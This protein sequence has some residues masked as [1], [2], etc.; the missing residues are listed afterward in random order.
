MRPIDLQRMIQRRAFVFGG[1]QALA[2]TTLLTRLYYLQFVRGEE[3][4][5]E[6]EGNRI[7]V[8]MLVP[9]RGVIADRFGVAMAM[10]HVNYKLMLESQ[11][12]DVA[13]ATLDKIAALLALRPAELDERR[14]DIARA[15]RGFPVLVR[16]YLSW[17]DVATIEFHLP[18]LP[19]A[20]IEEG[21]WRHYPF[22]DHASHLIGYIGKVSPEEATKSTDP[23]LKQPD[24]RLGKNGIEQLYE[25]KLRG[26]AGTRQLEV[27]VV[28]SPVRELAKQEA[29]AGPTL[30]LTID[31]RLQEFVVQR[32]GQ[33]S[34]AVVVMQVHTGEVLALASMPSYDPNEFS[35]GIK[36]GYWTALN[37][38]EKVPLLNK[39]IAGQYPPGS[40]F[41]MMTGLAALKSGKVN[42]ER[43]VYCPGHYYLGSNRWNCWKPEG[44]GAVNFAEALA[45][46]CDTYFY[47]VGREAGIEAIADMCHAFGLGAPS[48]LGLRGE[49]AGIVPSPA[50]KQKARGL[51]WNPGETINTSIG[52]GDVLT[53]PMQ[54]AIMTA[55]MVNGGKKIRP[56]LLLDEP[57]K[58]DGFIDIDPAHLQVALE[59]MNMVTNSPRGTAYGSTIKVEGM[60]FGGKTGTAQVRR[61]TIRGQDQNRI[62]WKFRH[63][64]L[65][66]GFAPAEKPEY[67][68]AV[69]I[70]HGGG[71]A[72]AA[73]PVARDVMQKLQELLQGGPP[74]AALDIPKE[75]V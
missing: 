60:S 49:R 55:R 59:G 30:A 11:Q 6:A 21:Q 34:G 65:F 35:K 33:E 17:E 71:G 13:R 74:R 52:Q 56:R 7:K 61:I 26:K 62:P 19:A 63:H 40:T 47:T 10:N 18:N 9:P 20:F 48:G 24:M 45:V 46:S 42:P 50:W 2:C 43:K 27:N 54:L 32:L 53:T 39:A 23:L 22:S 72:S 16:E 15:K 31:T 4:A 5:T 38:D 25:Q 36:Q 3:Y 70:E 69:L 41:K 51:P 28:G 58:T 1:L 12:K 75:P 14:V 67:C 68:C 29:K 66:V 8:Q 64:A 44:H 57:T 73:A 37:A